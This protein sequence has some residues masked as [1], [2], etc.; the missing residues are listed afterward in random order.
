MKLLGPTCAKKESIKQKVLN[1]TPPLKNKQSESC[2]KNEIRLSLLTLQ[3]A[4]PKETNEMFCPSAA[5]GPEKEHTLPAEKLL[6]QE[7]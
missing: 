3:S 1:K 2:R 7:N 5:A 6:F 4:N